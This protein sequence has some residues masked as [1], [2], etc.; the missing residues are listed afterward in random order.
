MEWEMRVLGYPLSVH[1]LDLAQDLPGDIPLSELKDFEGQKVSTVG[2]RLPGWTGGSG[3]FFGDKKAYVIA[4]LER[5]RRQPPAWYPQRL[6]GR[7]QSDGMG[8][9]WFQVESAVGI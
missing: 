7:L 2:I 9:S 5:D 4:R 6:R 1:P 3:F 8:T